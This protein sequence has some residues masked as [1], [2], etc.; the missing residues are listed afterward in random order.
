MLDNKSKIFLTIIITNY[1][2]LHTY[3]ENIQILGIPK[4]EQQYWKKSKLSSQL[5]FIIVHFTLFPL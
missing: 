1:N 5:P 2:Y 3:K 4:S